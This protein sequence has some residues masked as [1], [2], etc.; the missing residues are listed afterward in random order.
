MILPFCYPRILIINFEILT[1]HKYVSLKQWLLKFSVLQL[2]EHDSWALRASNSEELVNFSYKL[3]GTPM[4][5][6]W[7]LLFENHCFQRQI[8][9]FCK[10]DKSWLQRH[11]ENAHLCL[12]RWF[13]LYTLE[14]LWRMLKNS[15]P[16]GMSSLTWQVVWASALF[17]FFF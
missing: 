17:F 10:E 7:G 16:E 1:E 11:M 6:V 9:L 13:P 15:S 3:K 4:L 14:S 12:A 5:L 8:L 2:V